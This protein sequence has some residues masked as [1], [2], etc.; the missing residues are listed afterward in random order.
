[1]DQYEP[2]KVQSIESQNSQILMKQVDMLRHWTHGLIGLPLTHLRSDRDEH[3]DIR[4]EDTS[5][6]L[7]YL[8]DVKLYGK[9]DHSSILHPPYN[10]S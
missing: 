2:K 6:N 1:M 5:A 10:V 3:I 8:G 4:K 7:D 9:Y